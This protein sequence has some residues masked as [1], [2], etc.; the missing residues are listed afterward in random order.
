VACDS[1]GKTVLGMGLLRSRKNDAK[2][3]VRHGKRLTA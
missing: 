3:L 1:G 2:R